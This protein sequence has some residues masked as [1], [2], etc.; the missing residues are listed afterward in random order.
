MVLAVVVSTD[1]SSVVFHGVSVQLADFGFQLACSLVG[2]NP[3]LDL[4]SS[5]RL[6]E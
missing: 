1:V 5:A 4:V 6:A 3:E 2:T